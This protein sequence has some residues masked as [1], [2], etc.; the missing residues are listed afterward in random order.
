MY[1]KLYNSDAFERSSVFIGNAFFGTTIDQTVIYQKVLTDYF[2]SLDK[3]LLS[4]R[5]LE[6]YKSIAKSYTDEIIDYYY[7]DLK[8][9]IESNNEDMYEKTIRDLF[10]TLNGTINKYGSVDNIVQ[11]EDCFKELPKIW[12]TLNGNYWKINEAN[13][14]IDEI[15]EL[16]SH[17]TS[18][19]ANTD[20]ASSYLDYLNNDIVKSFDT[21]DELN[22]KIDTSIG[23]KIGKYGQKITKALDKTGKLFKVIE[24]SINTLDN[25]TESFEGYSWILANMEL[26][27]D[28]MYILDSIIATSDN[29]YLSTAASNIRYYALNVR[30]DNLAKLNLKLDYTNQVLGRVSLDLLHTVLSWNLGATAKIPYIGWIIV[31]LEITREFGNA[32]FGIDRMAKSASITVANAQTAEILSKHYNNLLSGGYAVQ[33]NDHWVAF[34]EF[35]EK[36]Y[37]YLLNIA[38]IRKLSE[39]AMMDKDFQQPDDI[40]NGCNNNI[41]ICD[42]E[43][44]KYVDRLFQ[45]YYNG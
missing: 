24:V 18:N 42:D 32:F 41:K 36:I 22:I 13:E 37:V 31:A 40:K 34:A 15:K 39:T 38:E 11:F 12:N 3:E 20:G 5:A 10:D 44:I 25:I 35:S 27:E 4:K 14:R 29:P 8:E 9:S 43:K 21:I 16:F 23:T 45:Y 1:L 6:K 2:D 33:S 7:N 26:L 19:F 17:I 30:N 28:N